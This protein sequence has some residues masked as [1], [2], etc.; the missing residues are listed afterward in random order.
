MCFLDASKALDLVDH[1]LLFQKLIDS[2]LPLPVVCFLSSWYRSQMLKVHWDKSLSVPFHLSNGVRQGGV[3]CP[4]LFS[5]YLDGLL[6]KLAD[7][8][9]GCCWGCLLVLRVMPM[10]SCCWLLVRLHCEYFF[11]I[12]CIHP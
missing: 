9:I 8:G 10:I 5:V 7:S 3:L 4:V 1:S 6:Q 2:G 12:T 11:I